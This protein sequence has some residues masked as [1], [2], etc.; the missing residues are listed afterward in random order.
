MTPPNMNG[1]Y[2]GYPVSDETYGLFYNRAL[3]QNPPR[4]WDDMIAFSREFNAANPG[5]YGFVMDVGNA[6]YTILFTSS[7]ANMLFGPDGTDTT[8]TRINSADSVRGM[9]LFHS[10]R[11]V[12]P[13]P[14]SDLDTGTVDALFQGGH[15]AMHITG[16]W[17]FAP[18][19]DAGIDFGVTSLPSLP[20]NTTP[21]MSFSGA[22]A[23]FISSF[24][25]HPEE[26]ALF[27][28][29]LVTEEMQRLRY[30]ITGA[31]PA[32]EMALGGEFGDLASGMLQQMPYAYPMPSIPQMGAYW[33]AMN[34]ASANIW[35]GDGTNIQ[36]E[37]DAANA[38]ILSN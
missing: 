23:M 19:R 2:W 20:G 22:R 13:I 17:N 26:A 9:Q 6:Y 37:L 5:R 8:D 38:A 14:S 18:F 32:M 33:D 35:D 34:S 28:Q 27:A 29:F 7:N 3:V 36:V 21:A 10:L 12:L 1:N 25:E 16:P 11:E 24:S 30:D 31:L 4:T 15:A